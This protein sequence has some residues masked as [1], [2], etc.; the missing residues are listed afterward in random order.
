MKRIFF[1][2]MWCSLMM[3]AIAQPPARM[4]EAAKKANAA[5]TLP[6][7]VVPQSANAVAP[8]QRAELEF[9]SAAEMP[10]DV[11]WRRDIYRVLDL[12]KDKNAVLYYPE[13]PQGDRMNLFTYLFKLIMRK[14]V[15]AY[16]YS[17]DGNENFSSSNVL[18]P[19]TFLER[20]HIINEEK[21]GRF[22]IMDAD[23]PSKEV[24]AYYIKESTYFDQHTASFHTQVTA[25]C[26]IYTDEFDEFNK[27]MFWVKYAD[28]APYLSKLS[29]NAS[30]HNNAAVI[31][32]DDYFT[33]NLYEGEIYKTSNL[34]G[35]V[36][37]SA[38]DS[39]KVA[40]QKR[41]EGELT[42]FEN[43]VWGLDSIAMKRKA[44]EQAVKDSIKAANEVAE[45]KVSGK[46]NSTKKSSPKVSEAN[47]SRSQTKRLK[48]SSSPSFSVRRQRH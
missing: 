34:Q 13:E 48:S 25:L 35:K 39:E 2:F 22:K 45:E 15:V 46:K 11:S 14:Q 5:Q 9:P 43:H 6:R 28:I 33:T 38:S 30:N 42:T 4:R 32:A 40:T 26:P 44:A 16:D 31:S 36:L 37:A 24:K 19:K 29:L 21:N 17:M 41:I 8:S 23:I 12:T 1:I 20:Y 3:P 47:S 7:Q 27:P 18:V 10:E